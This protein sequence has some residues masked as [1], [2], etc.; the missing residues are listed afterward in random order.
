MVFSVE[1]QKEGWYVQD[2]GAVF[3]GLSSLRCRT[4]LFLR[5]IKISGHGQFQVSSHYAAFSFW[6]FLLSRLGLAIHFP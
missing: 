5:K 4:L 6:A 1:K 3:P 2:V